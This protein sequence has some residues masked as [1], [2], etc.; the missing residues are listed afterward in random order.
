MAPFRYRIVV[1]WS[2]EDDS[3]VARV[4]AL[5]G[6]VAHGATEAKAA[7][8]AKAAAELMLSVM[9]EDGDRIPPADADA[10]TYSGNIR[11]RIPRSL[12]AR[13]DALA[14]A[15]GVSLNQLMVSL[16]ARGAGGFRYEERAAEPDR[17]AGVAEAP[18]APRRSRTAPTLGEGKPGVAAARTRSLRYSKSKKGK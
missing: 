18:S 13:L 12:H 15:E 6:C 7:V 5:E 16:L 14:A 17:V 8:E 10:S 3:F 4:P 1:G 2:E 11:L 9:R